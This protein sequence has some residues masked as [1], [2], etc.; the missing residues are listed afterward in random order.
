MTCGQRS[1]VAAVSGVADVKGGCFFE[2][3][4]Y[5]HDMRQ[6]ALALHASVSATHADAGR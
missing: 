1:G 5:A 4:L 6:Q 3:S 2:D